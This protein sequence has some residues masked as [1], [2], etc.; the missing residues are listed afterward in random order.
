LQKQGGVDVR[1]H[2]LKPKLPDK[3][4]QVQAK[5]DR[6]EYLLQFPICQ[7]CLALWEHQR[8]HKWPAKAT[9]I[10]HI[11]NRK[12]K[13][14]ECW[15]NYAST[16]RACHDWKHANE[17]AGRIAITSYKTRLSELDPRHYH[18]VDIRNCAGFHVPAW[19]ERK[20]E[21]RTD[22]PAWA[23]TMG[24]DLLDESL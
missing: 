15:S 9:E 21:E 5:K 24:R 1:R 10:E 8:H 16:C 11:W 4:W 20:L 22:L 12:G 6:L 3:P 13:H 7:Y 18:V 23:V 17:V 14:S 2:R 19:I